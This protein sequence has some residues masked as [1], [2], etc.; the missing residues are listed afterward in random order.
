[1]NRR[2][3]TKLSR[4]TLLILSGIA[5]QL[6]TFSSIASTDFPL[7][8]RYSIS[9]HNG[10]CLDNNQAG[11]SIPAF[12]ITEVQIQ[13]DNDRFI[14]TNIGFYGLSSRTV[15]YNVMEDTFFP[16]TFGSGYGTREIAEYSNSNRLF[17]IEYYSYV[18]PDLS[19]RAQTEVT[20]I[21]SSDHQSLT[22][23][24]RGV[25]ECVLKRFP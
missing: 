2:K 19:D 17:H 10:H 22:V 20:F 9:S 8:G 25:V 14:F 4:M 5:I 1:M 15:G 6:F 24:D 23:L 7:N 16:P 3:F 21:L 12:D 18:K 13:S 11:S